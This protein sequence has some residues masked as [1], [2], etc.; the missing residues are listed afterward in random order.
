MQ[1]E[2]ISRDFAANDGESFKAVNAW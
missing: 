2:N 1:F